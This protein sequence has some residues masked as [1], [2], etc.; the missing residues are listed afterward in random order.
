M[1]YK[2]RNPVTS[3]IATKQTRLKALE[4]EMTKRMLKLIILL[5]TLSLF[6]IIIVFSSSDSIWK[7]SVIALTW[8]I[9]VVAMT[10]I[11]SA[12][13]MYVLTRR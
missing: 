4:K 2:R 10:L 8:K 13:I 9:F 7:L 1:S 12:L 3:F 6:V 11:V 5:L